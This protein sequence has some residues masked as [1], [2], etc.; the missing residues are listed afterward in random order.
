MEEDGSVDGS[1]VAVVELGN[2]G[3]GGSRVGEVRDEL[4]MVVV[5][6]V[7][8]VLFVVF[9]LFLLGTFNGLKNRKYFIEYKDFKL[10]SQVIVTMIIYDLTVFPCETRF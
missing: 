8:V 7:V 1:G 10:N 3:G 4:L 9:G 5:V 2:G 6:V